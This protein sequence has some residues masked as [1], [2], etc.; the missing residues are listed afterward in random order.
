M[1]NEYQLKP[2]ERL[3]KHSR[4]ITVRKKN[5]GPWFWVPGVTKTEGETE[6]M[7][8]DPKELDW[9][10][11]LVQLMGRLRVVWGW[12][13]KPAVLFKLKGHRDH[14]G[15]LKS[16]PGR[17]LEQASKKNYGKRIFLAN[18]VHTEC[19]RNI[20]L[21]TQWAVL[22]TDCLQLTNLFSPF[23]VHAIFSSK[24]KAL[25]HHLWSKESSQSTHRSLSET[26]DNQLELT[27]QPSSHFCPG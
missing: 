10:C 15:E 19:P 25:L 7:K 9:L 5:S 6:T 11:L 8:P 12:L 24:L 23:I 4:E 16:F 2:N 14:W 1:K 18:I 26:E 22:W 27:P 21:R 17:T 3:V 13:E 20:L